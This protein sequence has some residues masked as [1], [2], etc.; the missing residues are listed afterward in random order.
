MA[1]L[2]NGWSNHKVQIING[3]TTN[4]QIKCTV[5]YGY[6]NDSITNVYCNNQCKSD[7]GDIR[8]TNANNDVLS[9]WIESKTDGDNAIIWIKIDT[10]DIDTKIKM[11]YGNSEASSVGNGKD[12]FISFDDFESGTTNGW[13]RDVGILSSFSADPLIKYSGNYSG[14]YTH[15]SGYEFEGVY[16][17]I[18]LTS[19]I[20]EYQFRTNLSNNSIFPP[21]FTNGTFTNLN[22]TWFEAHHTGQFA[23]YDSNYHFLSE[24]IADTWYSIKLVVKSLS[25]YDIYINDSLLASDANLYDSKTVESWDKLYLGSQNEDAIL[26]V[27]NVRIRKYE[28]S[29]PSQSTWG[30]ELIFGVIGG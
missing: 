11:Y 15:G 22:L 1:T 12:T 5:H 2:A 26:H 17:P 23:W 6:G 21:I 13:L 4:Y 16:L 19:G 24:C 7:F 18:S 10:I 28:T 3:S 9:Y 27:D 25:K 29:E 14:K 8:F 20:I 30:N